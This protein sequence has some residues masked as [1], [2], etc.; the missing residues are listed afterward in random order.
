MRT[1]NTHGRYMQPTDTDTHT[2]HV[3]VYMYTHVYMYSFIYPFVHIFLWLAM[4]LAAAD[5]GMPL[6]TCK[7]AQNPSTH[8]YAH[9]RMLFLRWL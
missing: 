7:K 6:S 3:Y 5:R 1:G 4:T 9:I 2:V 8:T